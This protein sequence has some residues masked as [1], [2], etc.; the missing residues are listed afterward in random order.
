MLKLMPGF[1][2]VSEKQ[3]YEVEKKLKKYEGMI[4]SMTPEVREEWLTW[5]QGSWQR[6]VWGSCCASGGAD[7]GMHSGE[8][9]GR[10]ANKGAPTTRPLWLP[11]PL[12]SQERANPPLLIS[13]PSRRRRVAEGSGRSEAEV[14]ELMSAFTQMK[15]QASNMSKLMKLGQGG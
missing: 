13:S 10:Q 6:G 5:G 2:G 3:L 4:S 7:K 8:P 1:S 14:A 9:C 12:P 11:L 15:A